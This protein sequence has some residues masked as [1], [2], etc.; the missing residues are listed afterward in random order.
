MDFFRLFEKGSIFWETSKTTVS[1]AQISFEGKGTSDDENEYN[2]FLLEMRFRI[3]FHLTIFPKKATFLEK[4][5]KK[6]LGDMTIF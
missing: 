4:M 1:G 5:G 3:F 6:F 2:L